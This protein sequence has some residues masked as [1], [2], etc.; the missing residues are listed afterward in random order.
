MGASSSKAVWLECGKS[1]TK[2]SND[3]IE[4]EDNF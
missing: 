3:Q 4:I 1:K 2:C